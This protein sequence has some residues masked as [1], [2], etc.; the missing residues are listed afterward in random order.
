MDG[1]LLDNKVTLVPSCSCSSP[2]HLQV[3]LL[4]Y[5]LNQSTWKS[6]QE[7]W[8]LFLRWWHKRLV[9]K[10]AP[11]SFLVLYKELHSSTADSMQ[12]MRLSDTWMQAFMSI[13]PLELHWQDPPEVTSDD[14]WHDMTWYGVIW[15]D[16]TWEEIWCDMMRYDMTWQWYDMVSYHM[17]RHGTWHLY[18]MKWYEVI[19]QWY[20]VI[21]WY[22]PPQVTTPKQFALTA[23]EDYISFLN[24]LSEASSQDLREAYKQ[25]DHFHPQLY[26]IV[27]L[28]LLIRSTLQVYGVHC[29]IPDCPCMG[30]IPSK[31]GN[32]SSKRNSKADNN[33]GGQDGQGCRGTAIDRHRVDNATLF[34]EISP[35]ATGTKWTA[36]CPKCNVQCR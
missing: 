9:V 4:A 6:K 21:L 7:R 22:D 20:D 29:L 14:I 32:S 19:W 30:P 34:D 31:L 2:F 13:T 12:R 1:V 28:V 16:M 10:C 8:L 23:A 27:A 15:Y 5:V 18:D 24:A 36:L 26:C 35:I 3:K 17:T 25:Q 33:S 11:L